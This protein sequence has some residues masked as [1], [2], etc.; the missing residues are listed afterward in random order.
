MDGNE[1]FDPGIVQ[2]REYRGRV[3]DP[4]SPRGQDINDDVEVQQQLHRRCL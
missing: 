3:L 4:R 1:T 2:Q